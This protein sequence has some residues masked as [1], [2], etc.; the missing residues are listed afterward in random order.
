MLAVLTLS[1]PADEFQVSLNSGSVITVTAA[2]QSFV[3]T[4]VLG[5]GQMKH[6]EIDFAQIRR[7]SLTWSPASRQVSEIRRYLTMLES[8]DYH[9]RELAERRIDSRKYWKSVHAADSS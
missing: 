7:L 5:D 4:D 1:C 6:R 2:N 8:E 3:W 9:D